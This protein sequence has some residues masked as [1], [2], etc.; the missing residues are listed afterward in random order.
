MSLLQ[1]FNKDRT[2]LENEKSQERIARSE[3]YLMIGNLL[4]CYDI[5]PHRA[6]PSTEDKLPYSAG[7]LPDKTAKLEFRK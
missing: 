6:M 7:Q 1:P 2:T 4:L 5:K 3:I